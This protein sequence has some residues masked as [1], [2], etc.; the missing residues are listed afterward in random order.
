LEYHF[1]VR[2]LAILPAILLFLTVS[3]PALALPGGI[4][5]E[6]CGGCHQSSGI[7]GTLEL[8]LSPESFE[9][10]DL[11]NATLTLRSNAAQVAGTYITTGALG[12]LQSVSGGGLKPV[13]SGLVHDGPRSLSNDSAQFRFAFR[14]PS[15][16]GG[17]RFSV[18]VLAAN[19]NGQRTGDSALEKAFSYVY[20]CEAEEYYFDRDE[21]GHGSMLASS[22]LACKG[23]PPAGTS[24]TADDCNDYDADIH[25]GA[26]ELC[27]Q[28]D[29][30]CNG[31]VDENSKPLELWP[32]EDG[33]GH[34]ATK[35]GVPVLGCVGLAGYAAEGGDCRPQDPSVHEGAE[36]TCN[37]VDEDCDGQVDERARPACG[38]G[39]CRRES[40]GCDAEACTPGDPAPELCNYLDD[41]CDGLTD[42]GSLCP[43]GSC[44][45]G[46]CVSAGELNDAGVPEGDGEGSSEH[47][48]G[49]GGAASRDEEESG[50][51]ALRSSRD[52]S[53]SSLLS[54]LMLSF[55]GAR[56]RRKT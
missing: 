41:D 26:E 40:S 50:G 22:L 52:L 4:A 7:E 45:S 8:S 36:E 16:P 6:G 56:R 12:S 13:S 15:A 14:A 24:G 53:I 51:C 32:D 43:G 29:N 5:A 11:V 38:E 47:G 35:D 49:Q 37:Y 20:G 19:G 3:S 1:G 44:V 27:D 33:D 46:A 28:V 2:I 30:D 48:Q 9:P 23:D 18:Y 42:E 25:P 10:G 55:L 54:T 34:Y 31:Q 39:W 17:V 21:D